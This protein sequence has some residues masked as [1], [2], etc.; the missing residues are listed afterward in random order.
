MRFL[1]AHKVF[2]GKE[3]LEEG[4]VLVLDDQNRFIEIVSEDQLAKNNVE[5]L[6]GI[7]SPGFVNAHCHLELSHLKGKIARGTGLPGFAGQVLAQRNKC[8]QE[9]L[10]EQLD[11]ADSDMWRNGI[12]AVGDISNTADSF[13]KKTGSKIFYHTFIELIG[14]RPEQSKAIFERGLELLQTLKSRDLSGSL[15]PHAPYSTS[16]ELI[17]Q[18]AN[19]DLLQNKPF[20][21]HNQESEEETKFFMGEENAFKALYSALNLDLSWYVAPKTSSLKHYAGVLSTANSL[22][23]HNTYTH[24]ED[25]V[26]TITKPVFWCFCPAANLYIEGQLPDFALFKSLKDKVCLGTDSLASNS[27]LNVLQEA[28]LILASSHTFS[29]EELLRSATFNGA[30]ALG[31]TQFYGSFIPGKN[32][33]I[34]L[35]DFSN[36]KINFL[37]KIA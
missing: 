6:E 27:E 18:I 19:F 37:K 29:Q 2:S 33:G 23:I 24:A 20:S 10:Q 22:L 34:N 13:E 11:Q 8:T 21:I 16:K 32:A 3:F 26:T 30:S 14:L 28:N 7:I 12:V 15:A 25:I 31:I 35:V 17:Q 4:S 5:R 9:E 36:S 1:T